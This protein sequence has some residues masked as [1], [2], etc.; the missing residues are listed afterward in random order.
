V[1]T[2]TAPVRADHQQVSF[3]DLW[4]GAGA[5][6]FAAFWLSLAAVDALDGVAALAAVAL[7][8]VLCA[9]GQPRAVAL[10]VAVVGWLLLVG[11]ESPLDPGRLA[12]HGT[13]PLR[14]A[15]LVVAGL[16]ASFLTRRRRGR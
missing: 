10:V 15:V 7:V 1:S 2:T 16:V 13:D 8:V 5:R 12:P 11:F 14:L 6:P 4:R 9:S 3:P